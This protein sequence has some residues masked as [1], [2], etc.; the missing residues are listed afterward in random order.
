M[1]MKIKQREDEGDMESFERGSKYCL[2][3]NIWKTE[4]EWRLQ[5]MHGAKSTLVPADNENETEPETED[6]EQGNKANKKK[7]SGMT[8]EVM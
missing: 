6:K 4:R 3:F 1:N 8:R 5:K 2:E 7:I